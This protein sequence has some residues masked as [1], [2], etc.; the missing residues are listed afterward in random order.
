M[1]GWGRGGRDGRSGRNDGCGGSHNV[2][3]VEAD[4]NE[5]GQGTEMAGKGNVAGGDSGAQHGR[6][7]GHGAYC[8]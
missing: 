8:H 6:G 7:F 5:G 2:G 3:A 4:C 1:N